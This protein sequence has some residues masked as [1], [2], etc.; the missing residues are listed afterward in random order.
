MDEKIDFVIAWV[1]G[2]D[3]VWNQSRLHYQEIECHNSLDYWNISE[4]RFRD[5]DN[6]RYWFRGVEKFAPWVNKIHFV[7]CGHIPKWLNINH[8]KINVVCHNQ[9]IPKKYLPTFSS[10]CIELN[11]HRIT[12]LS[13]K[14]VYFNDDMFIISKTT[15][16]DFFRNGLPRDAAII[17]PIY[18]VQNGIRAEINDMYIIN[19]YFDKKDVIKK[20]FFKWFNPVYGK[21]LIRT[22]LMM[23]F[24]N[25]SGFYIHHMP[26]SFCKS[27]YNA[28][29]N[30][31]YKQL[32]ETCL[33]RF[34][35]FT[36]LNQWVFEFW[37][38]ATG[39]FIPREVDI[40]K[41]FE[42]KDCFNELIQSIKK[43]KFKLICCND[44]V[45]YENI[46]IYVKELNNAFK[47]LFPY[48]SDFELF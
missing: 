36:D 30:K 35:Q 1:D 39:Q 21:Y 15:P 43:Q 5:W 37:Q 29:W 2:S 32:N 13:E 22:I 44:S 20:N 25:F 31:A 11:F 14:F 45:E 26:T 48:K 42:G 47:T 12:S 27:T 6:L 7:T 34:R 16:D 40:G 8:P 10:H 19:Q 41:M 28:V 23:P 18:L 24:R 4:S 38:Y 33:H 9:Y 46:E 17:S 3:P